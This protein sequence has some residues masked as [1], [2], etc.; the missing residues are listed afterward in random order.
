MIV[1]AHGAAI[2][3]VFFLVSLWHGMFIWVMMVLLHN[4]FF[5]SAVFSLSYLFFSS[6][7]SSFSFVL[8]RRWLPSFPLLYTLLSVRPFL[9]QARCAPPP[10]SPGLEKWLYMKRKKKTTRK[11]EWMMMASLA[12]RRSLAKIKFSLLQ[13]TRTRTREP[14]PMLTT[15]FSKQCKGSAQ[16][17]REERWKKRSE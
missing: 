10:M 13:H 5:P 3:Q 6:K 14:N 4:S 17:R 9:N 7:S 12:A 2:V 16:K 11:N 1:G 8:T 15:P